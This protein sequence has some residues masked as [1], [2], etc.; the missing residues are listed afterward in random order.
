MVPSGLLTAMAPAISRIG[1]FC[2][3][4]RCRRCVGQVVRRC[5][6]FLALLPAAATAMLEIDE[7]G[8]AEVTGEGLTFTWTD[9]RML[10]N[11]TSYIEQLGSPASN[12][13]TATGQN[14]NNYNCW[15]R[16]DMRW[17]GV[18]VS[19]TGTA[20]GQ[21]ANA[22]A[23]NTSWTTTA[24][25][26]TQCTDAGIN[27][28]GC[29][30]GGPIAMFAP[31]D[32]PYVL[33]AFDYAGD[34]SASTAIGNGVVTYQGN[35]AAAAWNGGAG[36]SAQTVLE[37]LAPTSQDYYRLSFW[38][39]IE[40]GRGGTGSGML[41]S[42]TLIQGNAARSVLRFFKFTQTSTSPGLV[43]A[44]NPLPGAAGCTVT[45]CPNVDA[46]GTAYDNR[47][48]GIQYESYLRG[49]FRFSV[50]Q[51]EAVPVLGTPVVFN[52][53][54]GMYFRNADVYV[55]LGQPFYQALTINVPR[56]TG[57]IAPVTDGNITLEI[58]V[59]PNRT[60]V[61][62][63][64]YSLNSGSLGAAAPSAWDYGYATSRAAFLAL[65]PPTAS[66][67]AYMPAKTGAT[68]TN[69]PVPDANWF[70]THGYAR[71]GDW[72]TCQGVGCR[73]PLAANSGAQADA[74]VGRN[75][76]NSNG[77]GVF[78]HGLTAYNAY[79]YRTVTM[80]VR[81]GSNQ[82]TSV[83]YYANYVA[84]TPGNATAYAA[85]GYGGAYRANGG[86]TTAKNTSTVSIQ[87]AENAF[88]NTA[89]AGMGANANRAVIAVPA[90]SALNL[91][92]ARLEGLQI[93]FMR[94]TSFGAQF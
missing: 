29:P 55:P 51:T 59:L 87:P 56:S 61:F 32:N 30:R 79:A 2:Q 34:G 7:V 26:M 43:N 76:W 22:G 66:A 14:A 18:N 92:D 40:V 64:F 58:P 83:S 63:R 48:L 68:V 37:W 17:Y 50:A 67:P 35:N 4:D 23:W 27:G 42:Q 75:A 54:E 11:P 80:D 6:L 1:T 91:G 47:T 53:L 25:N 65:L 90:N 31:H 57:S 78:F 86:G 41:K 77:D 28:L 5:L 19:A 89:A 69:Y 3:A 94:F 8:L 71:W 10:A 46:G 38:G 52:S 85:C 84:C 15:R 49:D 93:N 60:A 72:F 36:G 39:E 74:G 24:G 33:R 20:V 45:G 16:G 21:A 70:R 82:Y 9:F 13:C 12:T 88:L 81:P 44:F 62:T 73:L